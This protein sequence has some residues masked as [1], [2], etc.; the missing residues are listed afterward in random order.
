[1]SAR[2]RGK[3]E[4]TLPIVCDMMDD[5]CIEM[6]VIKERMCYGLGCSG[7]DIATAENENED[8]GHS[9]ELLL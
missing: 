2:E 8:S 9:M 5:G 4:L 3:A 6:E 7:I 1:M